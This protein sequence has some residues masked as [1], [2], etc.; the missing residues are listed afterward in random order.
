[1][2]NRMT[3]RQLAG[4][5]LATGAAAAA[6]APPTTLSTPANELQAAREQNQ[7]TAEALAKAEVPMEAEPA[8][9]FSA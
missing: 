3:R 8:F 4:A 5:I 6:Q 1:M 7:R 9:H 2:K